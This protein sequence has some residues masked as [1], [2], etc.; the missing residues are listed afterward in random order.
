MTQEPASRQLRPR[1]LALDPGEKRVGV[2]ISDDLG[3]YAHPRPAIRVK[4]VADVVKAVGKL[5]SDESVV[6]V[7]IGLPLTLSGDRAHQASQVKPL[8]A[9]LRAGLPVPVREVDERMSSAQAVA[10]H[11][12]LAGR[13]D[14]TLDSAAAAV[15]LQGVLDSKRGGPSR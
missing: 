13:R 1:L 5:V 12:E 4:S 10:Q 8:I 7:I 9:A 11:P 15:I 6:E 2:A 14:G 3:L